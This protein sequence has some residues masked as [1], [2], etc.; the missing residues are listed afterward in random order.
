MSA[1]PPRR[2]ARPHLVRLPDGGVVDVFVLSRDDGLL[3]I[4]HGEAIGWLRLQF[5]AERLTSAQRDQ[6]ERVCQTQRVTLDH[7]RLML[8]G[9]A[10]ANIVDAIERVAAAIA[11]IAQ[12]C[13]TQYSA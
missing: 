9:V 2:R 3:V 8:R 10:E 4:D 1:R 13:S 6:I 7:G 11:Q 12:T 5:A